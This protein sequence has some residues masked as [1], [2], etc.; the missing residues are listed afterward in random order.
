MSDRLNHSTRPY[1][2][3]VSAYFIHEIKTKDYYVIGVNVFLRKFII[4]LRRKVLTGVP[5]T[6]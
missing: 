3:E 2:N 5:Y 6:T 1:L 4:S